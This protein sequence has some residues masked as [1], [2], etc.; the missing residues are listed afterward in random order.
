MRYPLSVVF[1]GC[2]G[3][4]LVLFHGIQ[5]ICRHVF[6]KKAHQKSV[7]LLNLFLLACLY[8]LGNRAVYKNTHNIPTDKPLIIVSNHQSM[9][10]ICMIVWFM[11]KHAPKFISKIELG[12]GIPSISYNLRH[13]GSVLIDRKN[14]RQSLPVLA[15]FGKRIAKEKDAAVIFPEGTRSRTGAPKSFAP[16]G[17]KILFKHAPDAIVVPVTVNNSWKLVQDGMFPLGI[18]IKLSLE[19][20][21]PIAVNE[22]ETEALLKTIEQR[23]VAGIKN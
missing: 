5:V 20:Q 17:L 13:G 2:F 14:P 22:M 16:N 9:Y 21:E 19:V 10:D 11:K 18:G 7:D 4:T 6:G 15:N 1:Y 12:K 8:T 23:I 3:I